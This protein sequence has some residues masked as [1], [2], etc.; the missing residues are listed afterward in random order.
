M[1]P[2]ERP[3]AF[4]ACTRERQD[5]GTPASTTVSAPSAST[6]YQFVYASSTRWIPG[7]T[8][9]WSTRRRYPPDGASDVCI[10][11]LRVSEAAELREVAAEEERYR[12]VDD[13]ARPALRQRE[14]VQVVC[15]RHEPAREAAESDAEDIGNA[16]V[17]S[18]RRD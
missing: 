5:E 7:A 12:P 14:L 17:A 3:S 2:G 15:P 1:S 6:R 4:T 8:S 9:R 18:E 16:L 11:T 10:E 13:H